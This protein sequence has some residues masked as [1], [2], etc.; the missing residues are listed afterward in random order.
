MVKTVQIKLEEPL[1][2][3]IGEQVSAAGRETSEADYIH[4]LLLE[5]FEREEARKWEALDKELAAGLAADRSEFHP[6]DA[7]SIIRDAKA[8][9]VKNGG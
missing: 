9:W 8:G 6:L 4:D 7:D 1:Q 5:R 3:F 2:K